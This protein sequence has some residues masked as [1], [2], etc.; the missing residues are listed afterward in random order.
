MG[1]KKKHEEHANHERWLVSYADFITLLF[2]FFVVLFSSSQVDRSK[3]KKMSLAIEAAFSHFSVFAQSGGEMSLI[4]S[5]S[6]QNKGAGK[7]SMVASEEGS[8]IYMAPE[9][10]ESI[11]NN[12]ATNNKGDPSLN[13]QVGV[14]TSEQ[15]ALERLHGSLL[16]VLNRRK[17]SN[18]TVVSQNERGIVVSLREKGLFQSGSEKFTDDAIGLLSEIGQILAHIPNAVRV[19]GHTDDQPVEGNFSSNWEL[20]SA[21]ATH[22]VQWMTE[23]FEVDPSRFAVVGYGQYRPVV[24]NDTEQGREQ[25]R[26]VEIVVLSQEAAVKE[27]QMRPKEE[28]ATGS[29]QQKKEAKGDQIND[30]IK[31]AGKVIPDKRDDKLKAIDVLNYFKR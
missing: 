1:H 20:S 23:H 9:I 13:Q 7:A 18:S 8:P 12:S 11:D 3:T 10:L 22:V 24:S 29:P 17:F 15:D 25:N 26:R 30:Q 14:P 31:E 27:E 19:E 6:S 2:A 28:S 16:T 21:R 5:N 4:S